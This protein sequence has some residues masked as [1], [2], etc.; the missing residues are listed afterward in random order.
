MSA[1]IDYLSRFR[2]GRELTEIHSSL[3]RQG[4]DVSYPTVVRWFGDM[5]KIQLKHF[6]PLAM[7]LGMSAAER[8]EAIRLAA[9]DDAR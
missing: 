2:G 7:V 8:D 4:C 5:R 9:K 3:Q 1:L 6:G